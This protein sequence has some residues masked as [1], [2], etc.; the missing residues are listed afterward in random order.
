MTLIIMGKYWQNLNVC[1]GQ[2][3]NKLYT[4]EYSRTIKNSEMVEN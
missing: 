3:L 4:V 1:L 2:W